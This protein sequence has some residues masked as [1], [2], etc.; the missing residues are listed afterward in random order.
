MSSISSH[1]VSRQLYLVPIIYLKCQTDKTKKF[2]LRLIIT[3]SMSG[4][5]RV[6][7]SLLIVRQPTSH[8][9]CI[10]GENKACG[11]KYNEITR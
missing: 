11:L 1:L 10:V 2:R 9:D 8:N 5:K 6:L 3:P 4:A 7:V